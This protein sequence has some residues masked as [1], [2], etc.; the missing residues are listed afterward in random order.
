MENKKNTDIIVMIFF[1]LILYVGISFDRYSGCNLF[2]VDNNIYKELIFAIFSAQ[3]SISTLGIALITILGGILKDQIYGINIFE[4]LSYNRHPIFKHSRNIIIELILIV[5]SCICIML[6]NYNTLFSFFLISIG[7]IIFMTLDIFSIFKGEE[8]LREELKEYIESKC[9]NEKKFIN[10]ILNKLKK[11]TLINSYS[12]NIWIVKENLDLFNEILVSI[13]DYHPIENDYILADFN[14]CLSDI[15]DHIFKE[16]NIDKIIIA[17][18]SLKNLYATCNVKNNKIYLNI[19]TNVY[20]TIHSAIASVILLNKDDNSLIYEIE[21]QLYDNLKFKDED[22]KH[23][24]SHN[25][26]LELYSTRIYYEL[27]N[28]KFDD[29]NHEMLAIV[30]EDMFRNLKDFTDYNFEE[31]KEKKID[32]VYI[33][34]CR[35]TKVLIDNNETEILENTF[36]KQLEMDCGEKDKKYIIIILIYMYYLKMKN[37]SKELDSILKSKHGNIET[38][39]IYDYNFDIIYKCINEIKRTL[40]WWG[41]ED[42]EGIGEDFMRRSIEYFIIFRI[43]ASSHNSNEIN[44]KLKNIKNKSILSIYSNIEENNKIHEDF[45]AFSNIFFE[46][47]SVEASNRKIEMLKDCINNLSKI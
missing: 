26:Y 27:K 39:M 45:M 35:Y 42:S 30:K 13:R 46:Q 40:M 19:Y 17:L 18:E 7:I 6:K 23:S 11:D 31:F 15:F 37:S 14:N 1:I 29:L 36:F 38:F 16:K 25:T 24:L 32:E 10:N 3:V 33:Q 47:I 2:N 41:F 9:E 28:K 21:Y 12:N 34:L 8:Y 5:C 4:Y 22:K 43:L 20:D 44:E